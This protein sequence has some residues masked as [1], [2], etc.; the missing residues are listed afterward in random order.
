MIFKPRQNTLPLTKQIFIEFLYKVPSSEFIL[1]ST[2]RG[3]PM[4]ILL[5]LRFLNLSGYFGKLNTISICP[6]NLF[7]HYIMR[8]SIHIL[9]TA[10][11]FGPLLMS[12]ASHKST[13]YRKEHSGQSL[14]LTTSLQLN[15][16]LQI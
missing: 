2:L 1:I 3:K 7:L 15:L 13:Y 5:R 8:F 4:L 6:Q 10:I 12:P 16:F 14:R 9:L 11:S